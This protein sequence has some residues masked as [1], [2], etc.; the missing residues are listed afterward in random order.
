MWDT[1]GI[2]AGVVA[3]I[4]LFQVLDFSEILKER[5]RGGSPLKNLEKRV[6]QLEERLDAINKKP[7]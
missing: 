7:S 5:L 2:I 3:I 6:S 1:V 4:L